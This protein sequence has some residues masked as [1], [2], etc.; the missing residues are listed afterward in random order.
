MLKDLWKDLGFGSDS[1]SQSNVLLVKGPNWLPA[2][3]ERFPAFEGMNAF[4][5]ADSD[6]R[7]FSLRA[8]DRA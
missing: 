4:G 1:A 6:L 2:M 5:Q 8:S 3:I 7:V